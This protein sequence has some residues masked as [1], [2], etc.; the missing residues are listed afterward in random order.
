[1]KS[2]VIIFSFAVLWPQVYMLE[3]VKQ[4][5][6]LAI[7]GSS[8][9]IVMVN[10]VSLLGKTEAKIHWRCIVSAILWVIWLVRNNR[11]FGKIRQESNSELWD[12]GRRFASL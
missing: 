1:M 7:P 9:A 4:L 2:L 3:L 10:V 8:E 11:N 6:V 5:N 12:R